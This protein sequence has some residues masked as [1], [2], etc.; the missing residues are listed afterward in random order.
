MPGGV[1]PPLTSQIGIGGLLEV[2]GGIAI[3]KAGP[4]QGVW[5]C[6]PAG[7]RAQAVTIFVVRNGSDSKPLLFEKE[8]Q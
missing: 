2:V 6:R 1:T 3:D 8:N 4:F 5:E 7:S